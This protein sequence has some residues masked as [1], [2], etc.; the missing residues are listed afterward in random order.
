MR[1]RRK[2][3][4]SLQAQRILEASQQ[5]FV[6]SSKAFRAAM[7]SSDSC[8]LS[9]ASG[10][11][12][13]MRSG[14]ID[15][16]MT[17]Q[18]CC[19]PQRSRTY[20]PSSNMG[21]QERRGERDR[22]TGAQAATQKNEGEVVGNCGRKGVVSASRFEQKQA[23]WRATCHTHNKHTCAAVLPVRAATCCTTGSVSSCPQPKLAYATTAMP[24]AAHAARRLVSGRFGCT[25][26]CM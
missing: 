20:A 8:Q 14:W 15:L 25:S 13:W 19:R 5:N 18:P 4:T 21:G 11:A 3:T 6:P 24:A 9:R 16:G 7:S 23:D 22:A 2:N 10:A 12:C 26:I 1:R 17:A